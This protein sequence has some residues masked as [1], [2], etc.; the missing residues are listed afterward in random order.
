MKIPTIVKANQKYENAE[1]PGS[2]T[3]LSI[4]DGS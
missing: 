3:E 1:K 4:A 2:S